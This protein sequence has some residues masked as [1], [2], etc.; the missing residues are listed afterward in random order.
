MNNRSAVDS[1]FDLV[2]DSDTE[3]IFAVSEVSNASME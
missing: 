1:K 2:E 3:T